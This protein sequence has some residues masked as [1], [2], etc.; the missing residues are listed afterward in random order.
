MTDAQ[1]KQLMILAA[2][3]DYLCDLREK[4]R[5]SEGEY[6]ARLNGLRQQ[7]GLL[8]LQ[9]KLAVEPQFVAAAAWGS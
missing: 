7:A 5:I 9:P 2:R 4:K 8:P 3:A 6:F 1:A